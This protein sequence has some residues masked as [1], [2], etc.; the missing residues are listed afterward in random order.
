MWSDTDRRGKRN[1]MARYYFHLHECGTVIPDEEGLDKPDMESVRWEALRAARELMCTEMM[2]GKLCLAC[3][4]EVRDAADEVVH[5][6]P[7][8]EAVKVTGV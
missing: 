1:A 7:F 3:H 6:L 2:Q 5:V 4:I 8:K